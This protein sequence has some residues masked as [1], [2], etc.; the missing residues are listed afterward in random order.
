MDNQH[1]KYRCAYD[2]VREHIR[3]HTLVTTYLA[4]LS[5]TELNNLAALAINDTV[6]ESKTRKGI[7]D[8]D[9]RE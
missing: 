2:Y 1:Y 4:T 3:L 8:A 9:K 6:I 5:D 7:S